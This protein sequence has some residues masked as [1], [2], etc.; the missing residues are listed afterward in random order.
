MMQ[1]LQNGQ[2]MTK[3][4]CMYLFIP[5]FRSQIGSEKQTFKL[6]LWPFDQ[7]GASRS[8]ITLKG[9]NKNRNSS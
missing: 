9:L 7:G 3:V 4:S 8:P 5:L 1:E 6:D 2:L